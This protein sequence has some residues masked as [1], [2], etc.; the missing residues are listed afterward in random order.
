MT[1]ALYKSRYYYILSQAVVLGLL[2]LFVYLLDL[3]Q[4]I[5]VFYFLIVWNILTYT[6]VLYNEIIKSSSFHPFII[7][8]L[9]TLQYCG[10]S[11][12]SMAELLD[13]GET[14]YLGAT[15]INK[16]LTLGYLL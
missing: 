3:K 6:C 7:F 16:Y 13:S 1:N 2:T 14:V 15:P 10:F 11:P 12:I 5:I 9:I 4:S 8:A